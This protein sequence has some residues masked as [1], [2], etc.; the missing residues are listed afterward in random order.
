[1]YFPALKLRL[2][3]VSLQFFQV[4]QCSLAEI[5]A[6]GSSR[7]QA[8]QPFPQ[9]IPEIGDHERRVINRRATGEEDERTH[10]ASGAASI[11]GSHT[12]RPGRGT[13]THPDTFPPHPFPSSQCRTPIAA[14]GLPVHLRRPDLAYPELQRLGLH[15]RKLR[16]RHLLSEQYA[17]HFSQRLA[18][19]PQPERARML[20]GF[21][22]LV[23]HGIESI[24]AMSRYGG[25]QLRLRHLEHLKVWQPADERS[26]LEAAAMRAYALAIYPED[27]HHVGLSFDAGSLGSRRR[28]L[29]PDR[30][31]VG[32]T[33]ALSS[34]KRP[35]RDD[36]PDRSPSP[37]PMHLRLARR[38]LPPAHTSGR[39]VRRTD[40]RP[41]PRVLPVAGKTEYP[42]RESRSAPH[43][44]S[45]PPD[46]VAAATLLEPRA[47]FA[48]FVRLTHKQKAELLIAELP[49]RYWAAFRARLAPAGRVEPA[50]A[51]LVRWLLE[52]KIYFNIRKT[53]DEAGDERA[54]KH[55]LLR[56]DARRT[57]APLIDRIAHQA[58]LVFAKTVY[59]VMWQSLR[60]QL[61][62]PI[63]TGAPPQPPQLWPDTGSERSEAGHL[64]EPGGVRRIH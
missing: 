6:A 54:L 36:S 5:V 37:T 60:L 28:A 31:S 59:P 40:G 62:R 17:N 30:E 26:Q 45:A 56:V 1:M 23:Y 22:D 49:R 61:G 10:G 48:D 29:S 34:S 51:R 20:H 35:R 32:E 3:I 46:H 15:D 47:M 8:G 7:T 39:L 50:D 13:I 55:H 25:Q 9:E 2:I 4:L 24:E 41:P 63:A 44:S 11:I 38:G 33:R 52:A 14:E 19:V 42:Q 21:P 16:L 64:S 43:A 58:E 18:S 27:C 57:L 12:G 53:I